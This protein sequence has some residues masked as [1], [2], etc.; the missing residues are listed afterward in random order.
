MRGRIERGGRPGCASG[1]TLLELLLVMGI[2]AFFFLFLTRFLTESLR[3]WQTGEGQ[4]AL[5]ARCSAA[6]AHASADLR[7]MAPLLGRN[8][9]TGRSGLFAAYRPGDRVSTAGRFRA[10]F[11]PFEP[12][13][14]RT[15]GEAAEG[16]PG[17]KDW[18]PRIRMVIQ[19]APMEAV[20][21]LREK[22]IE[23]W[24]KEG[25][26][27]GEAELENELRLR[28]GEIRVF[29]LAEVCLRVRP[30][31][32]EDGAYLVLERAVRLLEDEG[33]GR[34][35]DDL[36]P[37]DRERGGPRYEPLLTGLLHLG[38]LF[39]SQYTTSFDEAPGSDRGPETCWD[40]ARAGGFPDGHPVLRFGLD[41]DARSL[42]D[43]LD[44]ILPSAVRIEVVVDAPPGAAR[45]ARL[46][47]ELGE[48]DEEILVDRPE[49][50]PVPK[51]YAWIKIRSEW[52]RYRSL[53]GNRLSGLSRGGRGTRPRRHPAGARIHVGRTG[54]LVL[55]LPLARESWNG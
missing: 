31:G 35:V 50:L 18:F 2:L 4:A 17:R 5:E 46:R 51:P 45:T 14:K 36:D 20:R 12:S 44:D 1:F 41:L 15:P 13:G 43:P 32:E 8:Y 38:Y 16:D 9:T 22:W 23:E 53:R 27:S 24:R 48:R 33:G 55:P 52:I 37:D 6:L 47:S 29:P 3:I 28:L 40:S 26:E 10:D 11:L 25:R 34:W 21:L 19:P 54:V 39:K 49:S 30:T 42:S 7:R